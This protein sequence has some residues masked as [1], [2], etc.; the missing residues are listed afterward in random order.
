MA[1]S[2]LSRYCFIL[3]LSIG[4]LSCEKQTED[5]ETESLSEFVL[6]QPGKYIT[7]RLDSTVF[8]NFGRNVEV[9]R[10]QVK[11]VVDAAITDNLGR[12]SYRIYRYITDSLATESWKPNGSYFIT[13][14]DDQVEVIEDNLRVIKIHQPFRDGNSW[15]GNRYLPTEP[16]DGYYNF[17]NDDNMED[18]EY[19]FDGPVSSFNTGA[20]ELNDVYTI[21]GAD[22]SFNLPITDPSSYAAKTLLV[23]RYAKNIGLVFKEYAMWEHQPNPTGN[24]PNVS[25]DPYKT[26]FEIKMWMIDHN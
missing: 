10:Y 14:L 20:M 1:V 7:Y 25:Y 17:S 22:E 19:Y 5:F 18:W 4:I 23:E 24:P 16:Y 3:L 6:T 26:G 8:T 11:H 13:V 9:R 21:V 2:T 12:P 15:K